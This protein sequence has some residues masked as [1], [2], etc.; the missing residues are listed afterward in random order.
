M[1]MEACVDWSDTLPSVTL[2]RKVVALW[3]DCSDCELA[4][5]LVSVAPSSPNTTTFVKREPNNFIGPFSVSL[6]MAPGTEFPFR[7]ALLP[8][9]YL[10]PRR[11]YTFNIHG[12]LKWLYRRQAKHKGNIDGFPWT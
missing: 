6:D 2:R 1:V 5:L 8:K 4:A 10:S 3:S 7:G 12:E 11:S 9:G